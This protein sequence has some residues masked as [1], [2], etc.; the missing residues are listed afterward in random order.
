VPLGVGLARTR[1]LGG[2]PWKFQVQYWNYVKTPAA[3]SAEHQ[4]RLTISPV[5]STP[6][7]KGK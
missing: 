7:N 6:W 1:I 4:L 5:L 3:F 2:R